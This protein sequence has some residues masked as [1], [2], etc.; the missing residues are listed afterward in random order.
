MDFV[1]E[2][3]ENSV[4]TKFIKRINED[5]SESWIPCNLDNSDYQLYLSWL[6]NQE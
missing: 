2:E 4:G 5:Q 1:Y 3:Q 6:E